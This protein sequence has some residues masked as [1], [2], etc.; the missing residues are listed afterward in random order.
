L[1]KRRLFTAHPQ[2]R[3]SRRPILEVVAND[4]VHEYQPGDDLRGLFRLSADFVRRSP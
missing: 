4:D 3:H 2:S 1:E